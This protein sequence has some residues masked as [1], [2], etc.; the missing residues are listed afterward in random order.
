MN[1]RKILELTEQDIA[2]LE[3]REHRLERAL[4]RTTLELESKRRARAE[5]ERELKKAK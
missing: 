5:I 3:Y 4:L 1:L 2:D